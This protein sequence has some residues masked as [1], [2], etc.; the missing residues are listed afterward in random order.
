M[1]EAKERSTPRSGAHAQA[2]GEVAATGTILA[3]NVGEDI[4]TNGN[5]GAVLTSDHS[6][7]GVAGD[8]V[9]VTDAGGTLTGV[10][11][12]LGPL[13]NNGGPTETHELLAGSPAINAGPNPVPDFPT[14]EFDQRGEGFARV[15]DGVADIGAFEVQVVV[16]E[17][18]VIT[19]KFTG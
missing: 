18:V 3:G 1:P 5:P 10:D 6:L 11:P 16:P 14:N 19:P 4:G 15:S 17:P 9:A 7:L 12:M 2:D 8:G 13:Q